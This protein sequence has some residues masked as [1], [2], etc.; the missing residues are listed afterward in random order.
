MCA[1]YGTIFVIFGGAIILAKIRKR[2]RATLAIGALI[3]KNFIK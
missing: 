1:I 2:F 3:V